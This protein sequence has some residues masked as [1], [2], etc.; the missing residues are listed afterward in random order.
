MPDLDRGW[1]ATPTRWIRRFSVIVANSERILSSTERGLAI[2]L[3][4]RGCGTGV[5][6]FIVCVTA[7]YSCQNGGTY[8]H[9]F[10]FCLCP[11]GWT[12]ATCTSKIF[13]SYIAARI[14]TCRS[15]C[16]ASRRNRIKVTVLFTVFYSNVHYSKRNRVRNCSLLSLT[17]V[18]QNSALFTPALRR[19]FCSKQ[20]KTKTEILNL[21]VCVETFWQNF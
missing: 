8:D 20:T 2:L 6:V 5:N 17:R 12:G 16:S 1:V 7:P 11:C 13:L 3:A 10:N 19:A 18:R 21:F 15:H 14:L 4:R 9:M